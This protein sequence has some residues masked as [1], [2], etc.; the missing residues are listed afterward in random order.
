MPP[1]RT[2]D[3]VAERAT[4]NQRQAGRCQILALGW[5]SPEPKEDADTDGKPKPRE[6]PALPATRRA[7]HAERGALV[8]QP[9]DLEHRQ[10]HDLLELREMTGN[11]VLRPLVEQHHAD[12][13]P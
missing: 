4:Q 12:G 10:Q 3:H 8:V 2:V 5:H 1:E 13:N 11:E 9:H 7:Q 6:E